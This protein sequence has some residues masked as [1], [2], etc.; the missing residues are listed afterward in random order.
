MTREVVHD[1]E[2]DTEKEERVFEEDE[3]FAIKE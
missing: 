3:I 1:C 2:E